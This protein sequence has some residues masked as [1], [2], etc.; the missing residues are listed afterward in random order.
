MEPSHSE[1]PIPQS[2]P[3]A[4]SVADTLQLQGDQCIYFGAVFYN[5]KEN[6]IIDCPRDGSMQFYNA[7]TLLP[8]ER[9]DAKQLDNA[10]LSLSYRS[11]SETYLLG[12]LHGDIYLCL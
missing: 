2:R 9:I 4:P 3:F 12:C 1:D 11:Q 5:E 8:S 10:V 6:M 7:T